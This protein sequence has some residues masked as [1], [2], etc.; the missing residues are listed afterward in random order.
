MFLN[1]MIALEEKNKGR[2][3]MSNVFEIANKI[4][5]IEEED[6]E[7]GE[8]EMSEEIEDNQESSRLA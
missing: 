2:V 7:E 4:E 3:D 5:G 1:D 6:E 8:E